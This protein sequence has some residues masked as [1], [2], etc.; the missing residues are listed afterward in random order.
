MKSR[1]LNYQAQEQNFLTDIWPLILTF[2]DERPKKNR[3]CLSHENIIEARALA[4]E[5]FQIEN[6]SETVEKVQTINQSWIITLHFKFFKPF[7]P[8]YP[9]SNKIKKYTSDLFRQL[10]NVNNKIHVCPKYVTAATHIR[11]NDTMVGLHTWVPYFKSV[12]V[13]GSLSA[14]ILIKFWNILISITK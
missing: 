12:L 2:S 1:R 14:L 9:E 5:M 3:N 11:N 7:S 10:Q 6:L 8:F 4:W 13:P